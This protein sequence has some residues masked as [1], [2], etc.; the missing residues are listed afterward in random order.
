M[1]GGFSGNLFEI[2]LE[3]AKMLSK[4]EKTDVGCR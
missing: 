1:Y 4:N 3:A 2:S